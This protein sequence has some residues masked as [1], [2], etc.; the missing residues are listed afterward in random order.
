MPCI[1][2]R[3]PRTL[4][5]HSFH[6]F[7]KKLLSTYLLDTKDRKDYTTDYIFPIYS[8]FK[9]TYLYVHICSTHYLTHSK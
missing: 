4:F 9:N 5:I 6:I 8:L 1:S 2:R 7:N 3:L